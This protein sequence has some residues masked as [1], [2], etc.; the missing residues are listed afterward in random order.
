MEWRVVLVLS[1]RIRR[2]LNETMDSLSFWSIQ[3]SPSLPR[4]TQAESLSSGFAISGLGSFLI[5]LAYRLLDV[6]V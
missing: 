5:A 6:G 4:N 2:I 1:F 3:S